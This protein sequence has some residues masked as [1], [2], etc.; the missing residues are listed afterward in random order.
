MKVKLQQATAT[1]TVDIL[2]HLCTVVP[3]L[4]HLLTSAA[5]RY[6][7]SM[8]TVSSPRRKSKTGYASSNS[9]LRTGSLQTLCGSIK[10][11]WI[12]AEKA[13]PRTHETVNN[14]E[15]MS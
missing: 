10:Q 4:K 12:P 6:D 1:T 2:K 9:M 8:K 15:H 3:A 5:R 13:P 14:K 11:S 7:T